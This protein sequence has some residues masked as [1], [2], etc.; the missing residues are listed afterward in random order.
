M[1]ITRLY[2]SPGAF[3]PEC[4]TLHGGTD[5][6]ASGSSPNLLE[7]RLGASICFLFTFL[8]YLTLS[9]VLRIHSLFAAVVPAECGWQLSNGSRFPRGAGAGAADGALVVAGTKP[10][11]V[12]ITLRK[13]DPSLQW[14]G[15]SS[16]SPVQQK[17]VLPL[18]IHLLWIA[19]D[20]PICRLVSSTAASL[21]WA[22]I[23]SKEGLAGHSQQENVNE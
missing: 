9:Q 14:T 23:S 13:A 5:S 22:K 10:W 8:L 19:K 17:C 16:P 11:V 2:C 4:W 7:S 3:L 6:S 1:C 20:T 18:I 12:C 21:M 15:M